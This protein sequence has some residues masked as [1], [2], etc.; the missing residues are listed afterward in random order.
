LKNILKERVYQNSGNSA[1]LDSIKPYSKY[2]LDIGCGAGDNARLLLER[3]FIVDG[4]TY[5]PKEAEVARPY[6]RNIYIANLENGL[7]VEVLTNEY[8]CIICSHI[9]EHI[10]WP[11]K[12]LTDIHQ[13]IAKTR[14]YVIIALPNVM[15][16]NYRFKFFMGHFDYKDTGIM[17]ITHVRWYTFNSG[18]ALCTTYNFKIQKAFVDG[19][20]PLDRVFKY[21]PNKVRSFIKFCLFK[22]APGFFGSQL[23]YIVSL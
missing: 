14:G 9:L 20:L 6:C 4:I 10:V 8:D 23:V 18:K 12:L 16:Y 5:S 2:I 17:D 13:L 11:E 21:L 22:I 1:V 19:G 3:G 15:H 7:P